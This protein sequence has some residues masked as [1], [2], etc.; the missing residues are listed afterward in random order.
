MLG[1]NLLPVHNVPCTAHICQIRHKVMAEDEQPFLTE[2]VNKVSTLVATGSPGILKHLEHLNDLARQEDGGKLEQEVDITA[3]FPA[4]MDGAAGA[5]SQ[6]G[7]CV[8]DTPGDLHDLHCNNSLHQSI[9]SN[10]ACLQAFC[11]HLSHATTMQVV[12]FHN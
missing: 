11:C 2:T 9:L 4:L 6:T 8:I 1:D 10:F 5:S 7:M 3:Q 12:C